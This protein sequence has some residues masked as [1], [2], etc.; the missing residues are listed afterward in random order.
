MVFG[1]LLSSCLTGIIVCARTKTSRRKEQ[2]IIA[3]IVCIWYRNMDSSPVK[4]LGSVH[5]LYIELTQ[6]ENEV[7]FCSNFCLEE[8][9]AESSI[10]DLIQ[11]LIT[12]LDLQIF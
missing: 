8:C 7:S 5:Q 2:V 4:I 10:I 11:L 1:I 12:K 6:T 3:I 9:I